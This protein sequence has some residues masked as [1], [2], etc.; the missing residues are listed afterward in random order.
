MPWKLPRGTAPQGMHA[1][2]DAQVRQLQ[3][4]RLLRVWVPVDTQ[5]VIGSKKR[6]DMVMYALSSMWQAWR[7]EG[8]RVR[9]GKR[10]AVSGSID[11][12]IRTD[13]WRLCRCKSARLHWL[14][15]GNLREM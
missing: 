14:R 15:L 3:D 9:L 2:R 4:P 13:V 1:L 10:Y 11:R 7:K 8:V 6:S 12:A 5:Q